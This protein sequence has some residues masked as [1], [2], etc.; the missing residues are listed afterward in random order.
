ME[1]VPNRASFNPQKAIYNPMS[2]YVR[3]K[4]A[5]RELEAVTNYGVKAAIPL[6]VQYTK[7]NAI[8]D[9]HLTK[10]TAKN[11]VGFIASN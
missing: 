1:V 4:L 11:V 7:T 9:K 5:P 2:L 3:S 10:W 8:F 6:F